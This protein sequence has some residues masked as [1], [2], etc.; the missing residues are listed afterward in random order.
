MPSQPQREQ[1][2]TSV[3]Q[4]DVIFPANQLSNN[5]EDDIS[6]IFAGKVFNHSCQAYQIEIG[7]G[8]LR[9]YS[10]R[11]DNMPDHLIE[12]LDIYSGFLV[13]FNVFSIQV[14]L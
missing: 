9:G 4:S 7:D 13:N 11:V 5:V 1:I 8:F 12:C 10:D 2:K 14:G 3:S 6:D